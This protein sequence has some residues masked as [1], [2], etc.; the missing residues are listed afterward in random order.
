MHLG[1][2][3]ATVRSGPAVRVLILLAVAL[4]ATAQA[5]VLAYLDPGTGSLALQLLVGGAL[6]AALTVKLF[7]R[8]LLGLFGRR[9]PE[10]P[11]NQP[12]DLPTTNDASAD[13]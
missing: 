12:A 9:G 10:V 8:R 7:W 11:R 4:P 1:T 3:L 5:A 2:I 13:R 6:G